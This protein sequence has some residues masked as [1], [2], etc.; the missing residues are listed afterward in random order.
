MAPPVSSPIYIIVD[1]N[2]GSFLTHGG[3]WSREYPDARLYASLLAARR[4]RDYSQCGTAE[5]WR[6]SDYAQAI[7]GPVVSADA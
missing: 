3:S 4:A 6:T 1:A 5:I 7:N 2:Q